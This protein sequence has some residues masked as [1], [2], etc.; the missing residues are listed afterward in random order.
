MRMLCFLLCKWVY[1]FRRLT[2]GEFESLQVDNVADYF[3]KH[4]GGN[5]DIFS[6]LSWMLPTILQDRLRGASQPRLF[7]R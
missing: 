4:N 5:V 7:L 3:F 1:A 2:A 6:I